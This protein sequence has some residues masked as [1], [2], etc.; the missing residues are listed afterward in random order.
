MV[1]IYDKY[2]L[3]VILYTHIKYYL[4]II[5]RFFYNVPQMFKVYVTK[6][7]KKNT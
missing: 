7:K 5:I 2:S 4:F 1:I 3:Y 6:K